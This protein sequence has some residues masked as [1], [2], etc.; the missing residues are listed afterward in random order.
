MVELTSS[1]SVLKKWKVEMAQ[2]E[3]I[4]IK[5]WQKIFENYKVHHG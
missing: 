2:L 5:K 1:S 4:N 3:K